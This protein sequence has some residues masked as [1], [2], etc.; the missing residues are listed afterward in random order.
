MYIVRTSW[1]YNVNMNQQQQGLLKETNN[2]HLI[3]QIIEIS[4][5]LY[6][7]SIIQLFLSFFTD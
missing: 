1:E 5:G 4:N 7:N 2:Q 6:M 3:Y